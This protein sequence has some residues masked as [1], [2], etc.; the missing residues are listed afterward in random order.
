[1]WRE[2]LLGKTATIRDAIAAIDVAAHQIALII[3][4]D[5]RLLGTISDGDVRR[6]I[7]RGV[8]LASPAREIMNEAPTVV[9]SGESREAVLALMKQRLFH[10]I[11][12][13]DDDG[14]V[15][16]L[17]TIEGLMGGHGDENW[18]VL[19]AGGL[20]TR[21]RPHT[22]ETP[23][24]LLKVGNKP[25]LETILE[26]FVEY[27]FRRF[28]I[29]VNYHADKV[30]DYFGDGS[31]WDV[32][33]RYVEESRPMGTGGALSILPEVP[34]SP[35]LVMNAD[36]LTKLNFRHLLDYHRDQACPATIC[37]RE[38]ETQIPY[39]IVD[40]RDQRVAR[41]Q[42]KPIQRHFINAGVYVLEPS[43][44]ADLPK[45]RDFDMPK[46]ID[47]VMAKGEDVAVFPVREFWLDIGQHEDYAQ[48]HTQ[49]DQHFE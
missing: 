6:A 20:G 3:D 47:T 5:R 29:S 16:G 45:D 31:R 36:L 23:K 12:V 49:Y 38:H 40:V 43:V 11:P 33:I 34:T 4:D 32:S 41:F 19:M 21:L 24:P 30:K 14:R 27:D 10:Q 39:G 22:D 48:A 15:V 9:R 18:V 25:L 8:D 35:L 26:N 28:Y 1:M 44:V 2:A 13:I 17:E 7:L 37:V 42:E 46:L